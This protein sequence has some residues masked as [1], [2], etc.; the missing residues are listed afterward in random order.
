M[1]P[2]NG[3]QGSVWQYWPPSAMATPAIVCAASVISVAGGHTA[4]SATPASPRPT[5]S[6]IAAISPSAALSPF[7]FQF[8]ASSGRTSGVIGGSPFAGRLTWAVR[9]CK[10]RIAR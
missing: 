9:L 2:V 1:S 3:P 7:I 10:A 6:A 8:P 5:A 4:I